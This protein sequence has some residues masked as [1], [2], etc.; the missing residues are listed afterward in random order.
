MILKAING[1]LIILHENY[2]GTI[3]E[4]G[5]YSIE[6]IYIDDADVENN[7]VTCYFIDLKSHLIYDVKLFLSSHKNPT[8]LMPIEKM[9]HIAMQGRSNDAIYTFSL[10]DLF[11]V[12]YQI[13]IES[14]GQF[15]NVTQV[16]FLE[17]Q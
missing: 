14:V 6:I 16:Y 13:K 3:R 11:E 1:E 9:V 10:E 17:E 2:R 8:N 15:Y 7:Y 12:P 4:S 5:I